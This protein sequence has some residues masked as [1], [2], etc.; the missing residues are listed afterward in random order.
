MFRLKIKKNKSTVSKESHEA[1]GRLRKMRMCTTLN[2]KGL[3]FFIRNKPFQANKKELKM[4]FENWA[5]GRKISSSK[6][7]KTCSTPL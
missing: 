3:I 7:V 4:H 2:C 1:K 6:Y 5:E